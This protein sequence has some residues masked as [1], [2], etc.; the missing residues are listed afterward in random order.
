MGNRFRDLTGYSSLIIAHGVMATIV[1]LG[2]V[3]A[4]VLV[5]RYYSQWTPYWAHKYHAWL[6]VLSLLL[7]T[8]VFMTGWF[9]VGPERSLTNPHHGIGVALYVMLIFQVFWGWFSHR[10]ERGRENY[11][12]P[13]KFMVSNFVTLP[14]YS[15]LT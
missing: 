6:Y 7:S 10:L 4:G 9:A 1:F 12:L 2:F 3:P 5:M 11:R 15:L 8:A 13:L 14:A